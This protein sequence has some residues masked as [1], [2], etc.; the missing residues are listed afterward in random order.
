VKILIVTPEAPRSTLGNAVT[1]NRWAGV[2]RRLGHDVTLAV[3][4]RAGVD[5]GYDLL[6]ALHARRSHETAERFH[7]AYPDRPVIVA[8]TGTDLYADLPEGDPHACRSLELA[9]RIVALQQAAKIGLETFSESIRS[10]LRVIYQSAVPPAN[11]RAPREDCFEISILS[12]LRDVKN[13]LIAAYA[14]RHLSSSSRIRIVHA[15]RALSSDWEAKAREEE[16]VNP[17][18]VWLGD[19]PHEE[20]MQ[21][22]SGSRLLILSSFMEG[23][24][25]AIAE[26]VVCGVPVLC[27]KIPGNIGMLEPDY[28]G[29]FEARDQAEL[30]EWLRRIEKEPSEWERLHQ[31]ILRLQSRFAPETEKSAWNDLLAAL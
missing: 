3:Q 31:H 26:A 9:T 20:A 5:G 21:L 18:Y 6:I 23:G 30:R 2:L 4:W 10:K 25:S 14:A 12:H 7:H 15:G 1:A 16:R 13:P 11:R 22:L 19:Q 28:P 24:A 27:S 8:L 17:R 29:Y